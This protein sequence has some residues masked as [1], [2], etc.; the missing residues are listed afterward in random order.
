MWKTMRHLTRFSTLSTGF[1]TKNVKNP[2][3]NV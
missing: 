3:Y 2:L 1:S